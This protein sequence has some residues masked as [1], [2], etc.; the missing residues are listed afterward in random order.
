MTDPTD[1]DDIAGQHRA[2]REAIAKAAMNWSSVEDSLAK[3]LGYLLDPNTANQSYTNKD[4][5]GFVIYFKPNNT[6]TRIGIVDAVVRFFIGTGRNNTERQWLLKCW[7]RIYSK[8][9][10]IKERRNAIMHGSVIT[11]ATGKED[12]ARNHV[13]L[14]HSLHDLNR[15]L[16]SRD[17]QLAGMS[18]HDVDAVAENFA[19]WA[20]LINRFR[21]CM[22]TQAAYEGVVQ[23]VLN[24]TSDP[25]Q[26]P[27]ARDAS[28]RTIL[29]LAADLKVTLLQ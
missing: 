29:Q 11:E 10:K 21:K 16:A 24:Q 8:I 13:R 19:K 23:A 25:K 2:M 6:E 15:W 18:P 20:N 17:G 27:V 7:L 4:M 1:P 3:L 9:N 12:T 28:Q 22:I 26:M 14:T 5:V